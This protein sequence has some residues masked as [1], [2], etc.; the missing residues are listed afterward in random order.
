MT[1]FSEG[2]IEE[3]TLCLFSIS[4]CVDLLVLAER[5]AAERQSAG[6]S[7]TYLFHS[8]LH[9]SGTIIACQQARAYK[10]VFHS[11][12]CVAP[13]VVVTDDLC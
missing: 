10:S 3:V 12:L 4:S 9:S 11:S 2:N 8:F 5:R 1:L 13:E 6:A 7:I